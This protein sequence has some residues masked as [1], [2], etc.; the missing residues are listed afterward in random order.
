MITIKP[1]D[2]GMLFLVYDC[3]HFSESIITKSLN[4]IVKYSKDDQ[5]KLCLIYSNLFASLSKLDQKHLNKMDTHSVHVS[6]QRLKY[7]LENKASQKTLARQ[8]NIKPKLF[9]NKCQ[10]IYKYIDENAPWDIASKILLY[11]RELVV[12]N[13]TEI[14]GGK[15]ERNK[16][17]F[18]YFLEKQD[19][20][21]C[22]LEQCLRR[23][24]QTF[25]LAGVE[26]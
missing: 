3:Q 25:R 1:E 4:L 13:V 6:Q 20:S 7:M 23:T 17:I 18:D 11:S 15:E 2:L 5:S 16:V 19:F 26:S 9:L 21:D 10:D 8:C 14:V 12:E 22:D 24:M